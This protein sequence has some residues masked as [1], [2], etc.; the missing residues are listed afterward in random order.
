MSVH[1]SVVFG[2][3]KLIDP[4]A[5]WQ[6]GVIRRNLFGVIQPREQ[7][8][9]LAAAVY[10]YRIDAYVRMPAA[11]KAQLI[12]RKLQPIDKNE[13]LPGF[14]KVLRAICI[15]SGYS[16]DE[17]RSPSRIGRLCI[18]RHI[19]FYVFVERLKISTTRAARLCGR[20]DH[21]SAIHGHKRI[22]RMLA[23][24]HIPCPIQALFPEGKA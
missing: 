14:I 15:A 20:L 22:K 13:P 18:A 24:G 19:A 3:S 23:A 10:R 8:H 5:P 4:G 12:I 2:N 17:I 1:E 11:C 16:R 7:F 9:P 21:T 6:R